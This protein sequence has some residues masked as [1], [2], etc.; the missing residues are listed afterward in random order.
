M[1]VESLDNMHESSM[2]MK[3]GNK[4]IHE[5]NVKSKRPLKKQLKYFESQNKVIDEMNMNKVKVITNLTK[6]ISMVFMKDNRSG[7]VSNVNILE[8][9]DIDVLNITTK[10]FN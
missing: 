5:N 3:R 7:V 10:I 4:K 8:Q 1:L 6:I 2:L 9:K